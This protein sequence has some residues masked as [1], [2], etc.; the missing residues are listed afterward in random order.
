MSSR[1]LSKKLASVKPGTLFVGIDLALDRN[2]AVVLTERAE[3][4]CR[5][6][7][8]NDRDGYDYLY[9]RLETAQ[10][11]QQAPA[12]MVAMEPTNYFWKLLA[13]DIEQHRSDYPYR[14]VNP[15][16]VKKHREGDQLGRAKDDNRDAGTIGDLARTGKYTETQLLHGPYAELRQ[17]VT[18]YKRLRRDIRRQKTLI[19]NVAGQLFPELRGVFK[20][21]G[22]QTALAM[23]R[24]HAA[25]AVVQHIPVDTFIAKVRGD[26]RG[27]RLQVSKLHCAHSLASRSVGLKHGIKALQMAVRVHIE[28][29]ETLQKQEKE[30]RKALIATFLAMPESRYLLSVHGL[31]VVTAATILSEIGDPSRFTNVRQLIKLAGTQPVPNISGRKSRSKTPMSHK[32]RPR[33]RTALFFAVMRL[34]Q[35]DES[36]AREYVRL[37]TR[38]QNPLVK[39]QALGVLMNKLLR[40][41]WSLMRNR[42]FYNPDYQNAA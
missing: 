39:M 22:G 17:Y 13:G 29:F 27:R 8:P 35:V 15:Y 14:L 10:E 40:I 6:G 42:T 38:E 4:V 12:V 2:V 28:T 16:T 18:L 7:F 5:F 32:G 26:L 25:A 20:D 41:L 30:V 33:L 19:R 23:L 1:T 36:F 9:R 11:R 21:F 24:N 3:Q 37:Q 34:I 31:G